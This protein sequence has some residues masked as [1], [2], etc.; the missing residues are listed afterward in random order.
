VAKLMGWHCIGP[1][2][3]V[4][5]QRVVPAQHWFQTGKVWGED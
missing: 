4:G 2:A 1:S 5:K 3:G